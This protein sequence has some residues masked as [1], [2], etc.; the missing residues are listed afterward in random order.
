VKAAFENKTT[1]DQAYPGYASYDLTK[2]TLKFSVIPL[3]AGTV[4]YLKEIGVTVPAN[5]IPA[6]AK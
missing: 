4:K 6:E 5:L 2:Q 1:I 3:H